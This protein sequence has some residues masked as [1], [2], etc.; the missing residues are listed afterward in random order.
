MN[1][2]PLIDHVQITGP[3]NAKGP[4]DTPSRRRIFVCTPANSQDEVPCAKKI[5]GTLARRAYR[6]PVTDSDMETLLSFY[7]AGK[8]QGNF[9]SGIE[10]ALRLILASPKFLFRSEPDPA[11]VA[12]GS[13]YHVSD[14]DLA[15]RLSFFLWS[16][17]PDDELLNVAAQGKLNDHATLEHQVRRMLADPRADSLVS[18]FA[19]QGLFLRNVQSVSPD[20]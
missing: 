20:Q 9:E 4:G 1:G 10:N 17:I 11:H 19:E 15:S 12:A 7:Q 13:I 14:L 5:L 6:R 2:L 3:F 16:S 8:N 18:N